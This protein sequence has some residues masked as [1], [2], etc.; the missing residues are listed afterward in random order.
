M[1]CG[2]AVFIKWYYT[3][4]EKIPQKS[5]FTVSQGKQHLFPVLVMVC[6]EGNSLILAEVKVKPDITEQI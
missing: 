1:F 3:Q 4:S 2:R 5:E 6:S